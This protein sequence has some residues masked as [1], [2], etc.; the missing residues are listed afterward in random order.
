MT[1]PTPTPPGLFRGAVTFHEDEEGMETIQVVMIVAIAAVVLIAVK[2]FWGQ[3]KE[4]V[5]GIWNRLKNT[6]QEE[7]FG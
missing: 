4:W 1:E 6:S 3:I 7:Q 2:V 5:N